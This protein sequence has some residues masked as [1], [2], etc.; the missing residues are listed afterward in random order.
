MTCNMRNITHDLWLLTCSNQVQ[1]LC[2]HALSVS[3]F[4]LL[5]CSSFALHFIFCLISWIIVCFVHLCIPKMSELHISCQEWGILMSH[6]SGVPITI[7]SKNQHI[8]SCSG[9]PKH[10]TQNCTQKQKHIYI[11]LTKRIIFL[12][13]K[14]TVQVLNS[15]R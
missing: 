2:H 14:K 6:L 3:I 13:P 5:F 1:K 8:L 15:S 9:L 12:K 4:V 11:Y 10:L 7:C